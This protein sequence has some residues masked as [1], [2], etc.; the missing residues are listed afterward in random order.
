MYDGSYD[1]CG[2]IVVKGFGLIYGCECCF[3]ILKFRSNFAVI[4]F[5]SLRYFGTC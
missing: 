1:G 3:S 5:V 2:E 4:S